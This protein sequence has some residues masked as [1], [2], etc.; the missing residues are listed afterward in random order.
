MFS[1][2]RE[3]PYGMK[4]DVRFWNFLDARVK[5]SLYEE[6]RRW[7]QK[8]ERLLQEHPEFYQAYSEFM[9]EYED[10]GYITWKNEDASSTEERY[11]MPH[12]AVCISSNST[13]H[14]RVVLDGSWCSLNR[15]CLHEM[16]LGEQYNSVCTPSFYGSEHTEMHSPQI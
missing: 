6:A 3:A 14:P 5:V 9:Q 7:F 12:H 13:S 1:T 16:L 4:R 2:L 10:L 11:F 8:L 15:I